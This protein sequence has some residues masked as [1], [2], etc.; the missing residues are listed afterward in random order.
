MGS[1]VYLD[2]QGNPKPKVYVDSSGNPIHSGNLRGQ[3]EEEKANAATQYRDMA[4]ALGFD[5]NFRML[6]PAQQ[7]EH[8]RNTVHGA[9]PIPEP[10]LAD[11][12][13]PGGDWMGRA[14]QGIRSLLPEVPG[15]VGAIGGAARGGAVGGV[16][17]AIAGGILGGGGAEALR[18]LWLKAMQGAPDP[19]WGQRIGGQ[20]VG[21]AMQGMVPAPSQ[22]AL[23]QMPADVAQ[24]ERTATVAQDISP[25]VPIPARLGARTQRAVGRAVAVQE[26]P[27]EANRAAVIGEHEAALGRQQAARDAALAQ[28]P[29]TRGAIQAEHEAAL[30]GQRASSEATTA[31]RVATAR[32]AIGGENLPKETAMRRAAEVREQTANKVR[33]AKQRAYAKFDDDAKDIPF[34]N[35]P[36]VKVAAKM[37]QDLERAD[38]THPSLPMLKQMAGGPNTLSLPEAETN[39]GLLKDIARTAFPAVKGRT[40]GTAAYFVEKLQ[41]QVDRI[42]QE[43]GVA[44]ALRRGRALTRK[45]HD[46]FGDNPQPESRVAR[47]VGTAMQTRPLSKLATA[48]DA[49]VARVRSFLQQ[50]GGQLRPEMARQMFDDIVKGATDPTGAFDPVKFRTKLKSY[51]DETLRKVFRSSLADVERVGADMPPSRVVPKELGEFSTLPRTP[52]VTMPPSP[53]AFEALPAPRPEL[54]NLAEQAATPEPA[55]FL[56]RLLRNDDA[57]A[58][59]LQELL[60]I[61]PSERSKLARHA[62][63]EATQS[64]NTVASWAKI[65]DRTKRLLLPNTEQRQFVNQF[66]RD[67]EVSPA[68]EAQKNILAALPGALGFVVKSATGHG[69]VFVRAH[70]I[71][72]LLTSVG[73]AKALAKAAR[74]PSTSPEAVRLMRALGIGMP[75]AVRERESEGPVPIPAMPQ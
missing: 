72:R 20:M 4:K 35:Q 41:S 25:T 55:Q 53:G 43:N 54:G 17:G 11:K 45:L 32:T 58:V 50:T 64:P 57:S 26:A 36:A 8:V 74:T 46:T 19:D 44:Q 51:G 29:A 5:P 13:A 73:G 62:F 56:A 3:Q 70:E 23:T 37:V 61:A 42:A 14:E 30:A 63:Q 27:R 16:P 59:A 6:T 18:Q 60:R 28:E 12:Y 38:P 34:D 49:G 39:L 33:E 52:E 75:E 7:M 40:E 31:Q 47:S 9:I 24:A 68:A 15:A 67:L 69:T 48:G 10:D 65:G 22:G 66:F 1:K 21:G 71:Y 2:D